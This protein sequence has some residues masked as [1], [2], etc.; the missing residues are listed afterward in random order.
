MAGGGAAARSI[1]VARRLVGPGEAFLGGGAPMSAPSFRGLV[2][3]TTVIVSFLC[4]I[5]SLPSEG[6]GQAESAITRDVQ[7]ANLHELI[8]KSDAL[9]SPPIG[10]H[11][12]TEGDTQGMTPSTNAP[13]PVGP[14]VVPIYQQYDPFFQLRG[15]QAPQ[16]LG[17]R[18]M[19]SLGIAGE[20]FGSVIGRTFGAKFVD[21]EVSERLRIQGYPGYINVASKLRDLTVLSNAY[22]LW[23]MASP[24]KR[25]GSRPDRPRFRPT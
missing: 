25:S 14:A 4:R 22:G 17:K 15:T 1:L 9:Q 5:L 19:Q 21:R 23:L 20:G 13:E 6:Q 2:C 10:W 8:N 24:W 3:K 16:Y 7:I 12:Q 11:W 18:H